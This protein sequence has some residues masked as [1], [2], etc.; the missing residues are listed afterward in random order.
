MI[1]T[2][3]GPRFTDDAP[4]L[5]GAERSALVAAM[6]EHWNRVRTRDAPR[7]VAEAEAAAFLAG[8]FEKPPPH[9]PVAA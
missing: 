6:V 4:H 2:P 8:L 9:E 7:E 3:S 5:R 1:D